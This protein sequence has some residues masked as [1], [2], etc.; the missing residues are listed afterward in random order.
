MKLP[1]FLNKRTILLSLV[2]IAAVSATVYAST[3]NTIECVVCEWTAAK[4]ESFLTSNA[5]ETE[6]ITVLDKACDIV[7]KLYQ[8]GCVQTIK[9]YIPYLVDTLIQRETPVVICQQLKVCATSMI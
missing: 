7:P 3:T 6:V 1:S 4:V 9:E 8:S 5:T 2:I